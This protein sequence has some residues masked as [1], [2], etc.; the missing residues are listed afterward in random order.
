MQVG[1]CIQRKLAPID[2]ESIC[3]FHQVWEKQEQLMV[4]T[5]Q[6]NAHWPSVY[7][8]KKKKKASN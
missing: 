4:K 5:R 2:K 3:N 8:L 7:S 1:L 6:I